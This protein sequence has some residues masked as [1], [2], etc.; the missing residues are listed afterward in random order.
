LRE[1][2]EAKP[3]RRK[4]RAIVR[5]A[6]VFGREFRQSFVRRAHGVAGLAAWSFPSFTDRIKRT[7]GQIG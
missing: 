5:L 7:R 6:P 1:A 4:R 3:A 2:E